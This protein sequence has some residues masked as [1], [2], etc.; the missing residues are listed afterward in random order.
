MVSSIKH[1]LIK[2]VKYAAAKTET[3]HNKE[4][5]KNSTVLSE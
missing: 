4:T 5:M 1:S 2:S 3:D